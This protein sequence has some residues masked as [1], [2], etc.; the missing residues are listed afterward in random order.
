MDKVYS[1]L[2]SRN[3]IKEKSKLQ[4]MVTTREDLRSKEALR[5]S[6]V[7]DELVVEV[8]RKQLDRI[9]ERKRNCSYNTLNQQQKQ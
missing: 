9:N 3:I 6:W 2:I 7:L 8:M 5:Q 1:K 4:E